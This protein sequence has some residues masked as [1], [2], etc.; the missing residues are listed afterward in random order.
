MEWLRK[1]NSLNAPG[2]LRRKSSMWGE[3]KI[4]LGP[5]GPN[6]EISWAFVTSAAKSPQ[7]HDP[8][9][10]ARA[11][12]RALGSE[13]LVNLPNLSSG[14]KEVC[15]P[16][17]DN[18]QETAIPRNSMHI[19]VSISNNETKGWLCK[20]QKTQIMISRAGENPF[21]CMSLLCAQGLPSSL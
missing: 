5:G 1:R 10:R 11:F 17:F 20:N 19:F 14:F 2:H 7:P 3:Q 4:G 9:A 6:N 12:S 15:L 18:N 8:M 16:F 13:V 21:A